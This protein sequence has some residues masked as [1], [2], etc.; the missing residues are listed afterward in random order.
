VRIGVSSSSFTSMLTSISV[1]TLYFSV[2]LG[3]KFAS[4]ICV[5]T[6]P[7]EAEGFTHS[8][9]VGNVTS[10][11]LCPTVAVKPVGG[12]IWAMFCGQNVLLESS[13]P[14]TPVKPVTADS[15]IIK[16][17]LTTKYVRAVLCDTS[18]EVNR[19]FSTSKSLSAVLLD[20][21]NEVSWLLLTY[22]PIS[23]VLRDTSNEVSWLSLTTK[24]VSAVLCDTSNEVSSL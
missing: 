8:Q 23:A 19:L 10:S 13:P 11:N 17:L 18:N 4:C 7:T 22:K 24:Y 6:V 5:P 2:S 9:P 14:H 12:T 20:T 15:S 16:L 3:V 1:E 21:S